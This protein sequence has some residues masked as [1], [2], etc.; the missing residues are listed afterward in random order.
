MKKIHLLP[1]TPRVTPT[2]R[3]HVLCACTYP[4]A[5]HKVLPPRLSLAMAELGINQSGY[6]SRERAF[7]HPH[8][9]HPKEI[10]KIKSPPTPQCYAFQTKS[11]SA[12]ST[13]C[14]VRSRG[15]GRGASP[16]PTDGLSLLESGYERDGGKR[17]EKPTAGKAARTCCAPGRL[18]LP[19]RH[20]ELLRPPAPAGGG[21][22]GA[23]VGRVAL[24]PEIR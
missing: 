14:S 15:A 16:V 12:K 7:M 22:L 3:V 20:A 11:C 19:P 17:E 18:L 10:N 5:F 8:A 21:C 6:Q 2:I 9:C 1:P 4:P 13:A 24:A 23:G